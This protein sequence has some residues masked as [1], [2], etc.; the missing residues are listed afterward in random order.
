MVEEGVVSTAM[1]FEYKRPLESRG[2]AP[3]D[4]RPAGISAYRR[5]YEDFYA[6]EFRC[7]PHPP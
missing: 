7:A 5:V 1:G 2:L 3:R 4:D 6:R